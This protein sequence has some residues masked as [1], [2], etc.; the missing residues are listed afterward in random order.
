MQSEKP[1]PARTAAAADARSGAAAR[2]PGRGPDPRPPWHDEQP[3]RIGI[4]SCLLGN[5]VRWNGGHKRDPF[6]VDQLARFVEWVPVCPE[7]EVGMGVPRETV[8]LVVRDGAVHMVAGR[9]G[10]DWTA[11]MRA[12]AGRRV[13]V[14]EGLDLCG[15]VL[16]KASPSCGL[17][18]VPVRDE[19]GTRRKSGRGLFAEALV[20]AQE[21]LPVE[22]EGRLH[23]PRLRENWIER[24]FAYRRLRSLFT[25][26]WSR[27]G[28]VAFHTAHKLQLMAHA[29]GR[30]AELGRVVA[31]AK[32]L[33]RT[34]ARARYERGFMEALGRI[35]T[36]RRHVNVL[37]H[38]L[39]FLRDGLDDADRHELLGLIE[40][41]G[42]GLLPLVV[43]ITLIRHH[44]ARL[45][46]SY[47]ADQVYLEP[48]PR[49]LMLRN[50]V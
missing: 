3:I 49:E 2:A 8:Q 46:I 18:R 48:H 21:L 30:H 29:P 15:F 27:R 5:A 33:G 39:G 4:S 32:A 47:L 23:D 35:A 50:H 45:G 26:R 31:E 41:Y 9:S 10:E 6:L 38:V 16:K 34:A 44:V 25:G 12:F 17:E 20:G 24:V 19:R 28:L 7:V 22:E 14:L 37:H 42:R 36:P 13:G 1:A 43:P 11:R 40:D